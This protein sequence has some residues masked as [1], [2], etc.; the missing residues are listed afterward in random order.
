MAC[1]CFCS[2]WMTPHR[3]AVVLVILF[4]ALTGLGAFGTYSFFSNTALD[5]WDTPPGTLIARTRTLIDNVLVLQTWNNPVYLFIKSTNSSQSVLDAL[6]PSGARTL[7]VLTNDVA[8][9]MTAIP[10]VASALTGIYAYYTVE[11][12]Q[13]ERF[14]AGAHGEYSLIVFS[15]AS[16]DSFLPD[17]LRSFVANSSATYPQFQLSVTSIVD[18]FNAVT[19]SVLS[20]LTLIDAI[21]LPI[22]FLLLG[23]CIGTVRALLVP[24][25]VLPVSL[26]FAFSGAYFLT[27]CITVTAIAPEMISAICVALAFDYSLFLLS[28]FYEEVELE[29]DQLQLLSP[30]EFVRTIDQLDAQQKANIIR[31]TLVSCMKN[32]VVSGVTIALA[33]IGIS[34]INVTF[35][36]SIA[37]GACISAVAAVTVAVF[38]TPALMLLIFRCIALDRRTA[39]TWT[40]CLQSKCPCLRSCCCCCSGEQIATV[41]AVD[42]NAAFIPSS[43]PP[44]P[45]LQATL[46]THTTAAATLTTTAVSQANKQPDQQSDDQQKGSSN[47]S[48]LSVTEPISPVGGGERPSF[49]SDSFSPSSSC[50]APAGAGP[51]SLYYYRLSSF[52]FRHPYITISVVLLLSAPLI[53]MVAFIRSDFSVY[54]EVPYTLQETMDFQTVMSTFGPQVAEA[55]VVVVQAATASVL[56]CA[57][58]DALNG[59]IAG[60]ITTSLGLSLANITAF[61][62]WNNQLIDCATVNT[63]L[64]QS[65]L[66]Q[67]LYA[68]TVSSD[69]VTTVINAAVAVD[70]YG[71][72]PLCTTTL[73]RLDTLAE[74]LGGATPHNPLFRFVG[75]NG[76]SGDS[77]SVMLQVMQQFP[78]LVGIVLSA[79]SLVV[80]LFYRSVYNAVR[81]IFSMALSVLV[82]LG[83]GVIVFENNDWLHPVWAGLDHVEAFMWLVLV[84][85][86]PLMCSLALDYDLFLVARVIELRSE[87]AST[88]EEAVCVAVQ[89]TGSVI[90]YAGL[91]MAVAVGSLTF[92]RTMLLAQLGLVILIAVLYDTLITRPILVPALMALLPERAVWW[93][94]SMPN[95]FNGSLLLV[96]VDD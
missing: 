30:S 24:L 1:S 67:Y 78:T 18:L 87:S 7:A 54:S 20:D 55:Y 91:I 88:T 21:S 43:P 46:K 64:L 83:V 39:S 40:A 6:M 76:P 8:S 77:W 23:I 90:T 36:R 89:R 48:S 85:A 42:E 74:S 13:P 61:T 32:I 94:R 17:A 66:Y 19:D 11:G 86:V 41:A 96:R 9:A 65:T 12:Y 47:R 68:Q 5:F 22:A 80:A 35:I 84:L 16:G 14:V 71:G 50:S 52:A 59:V 25:V 69:S 27:L 92:A 81:M 93:P 38:F 44:Q 45:Q 15:W 62:V 60:N 37:L 57:F 2:R 34:F 56:D 73:N 33:F 63:L 4:S 26:C 28:R 49:A 3:L 53:V 79:I 31:R 58:I 75:Y 72:N 51:G 29:L 95:N 70:P 10:N 82:A